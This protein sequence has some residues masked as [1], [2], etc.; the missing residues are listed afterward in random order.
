[1]IP[2]LETNGA[3]D[4]L[5]I[6]DG[7][8][9]NPVTW[10]DVWAFGAG[11]GAGLVPID[12]GGTAR[13]DTF[14]TEIVADA[15]YTIQKN[16]EFGDGATSTYFQSKNES[17]Y[18]D[19]GAT[20]EVM[21]EATLKLG[22]IANGFGIS[23]SR[24][25]FGPSA[26]WEILNDTDGTI[27]IYVSE[28]HLRTSAQGAFRLGNSTFINT[29]FS[30]DYPTVGF[31]NRFAFVSGT[32]VLTNCYANKLFSSI[33]SAATLTIVKL[34]HNMGSGG[35]GLILQ[36]NVTVQELDL[37]GVRTVRITAAFTAI[38]KDLIGDSP[39]MS[40]T[41][42][43]AA[44]IQQY[45]CNI[46]VTDKDGADLEDV[47]VLCEDE[48]GASVFSAVIDVNGDIAEQVIDYKKWM[49]TDET[50]TEYSP[51]KFT[52][53]HAD[54]PDLVMSDVIVDHPIV[55]E[56]DMGQSNSDLQTIMETAIDAKI[57]LTAGVVDNVNAV[58]ADVTTDSASRTASK[59]G[60]ADVAGAEVDITKIG[61]ATQSAADL[62]DFADTGYDPVAH[63]IETCKVNDDMV[64]TDGAN[65]TT[66]LNA[67][68][69][70]S[71]CE[72]AI[73]TKFAFASGDVKATLDGEEVTTDTASRTAAKAD[74]SALVTTSALSTHDGKL[75]AVD[76]IVD[77][78]IA[79]LQ[80]GGTIDNLLDA[81]KAKTDNLKDSW[82]DPTAEESKADVSGLQP[83]T[84]VNV[85]H[86]SNIIHRS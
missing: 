86:I 52:F 27:L 25:D 51:H 70:Q 24:W 59:A 6:T 66:P 35:Y 11:G 13:V 19:D 56:I 20:F 22:D 26:D 23:G 38:L 9:G 48:T 76:S 21:G 36:N 53:T 72:D 37:V 75:D 2:T 41:D 79:L 18:F 81:V 7:I 4:T 40:F 65:T 69:T 15:I 29:T 1:M 49:G 34:Q 12:G 67:S 61:G 43:S 78:V 62:K 28:L 31:K 10:D 71:E 46:H 39:I 84:P 54:Y 50:L 42:A 44:A 63:K 74:V 17:V 85:S 82:N 47:T 30:G 77:S 3:A 32:T 57:N 16:I 33:F 64:G 68:E 73:D 83:V 60:A 14:M 5:R 58:D 8:S 55:W 80:D 45:T